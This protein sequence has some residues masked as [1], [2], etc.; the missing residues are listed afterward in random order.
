MGLTKNTLVLLGVGVSD[1][2][3][4]ESLSSMTARVN[5]MEIYPI[6]VLSRIPL[7]GDILFKH[8]PPVYLTAF[9]VIGVW[10][11]R[12]ECRLRWL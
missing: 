4:R 7:V 3:Y 9:L 12:A 5:G 2:L 6:P 1:Y 11:P 8:T 10:W